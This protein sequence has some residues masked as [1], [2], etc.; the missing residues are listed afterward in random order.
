MSQTILIAADHRGFPLKAKV[1]AWLK[2]HGYA[3]KDLGTNS[4][5]RCDAMDYAKAMAESFKDNPEQF[6]ILICG[7][8]HAMAMTANRYKN[9]RAIHCTSV[10][11][12]RLG[13]EHNDANV[14]AIGA[15]ITDE[16]TSLAILEM[17]LKTKFLG[18][19]YAER[20]GK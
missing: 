4:E 12:A 2:E 15:D 9:I 3:P 11:L 18:G 5:E 7:S 1:I 10:D 20:R 14:V 13:R 16:K 19:R 8:G 17:F 6:G